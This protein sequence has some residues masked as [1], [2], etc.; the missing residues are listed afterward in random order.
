MRKLIVVATVA[1]AFAIG[2]GVSLAT[3]PDSNGTIHGCYKSQGNS[4]SKLNVID[5]DAGQ[6]CSKGS[7]ELDWSQTGPRG[8]SNAYEAHVD[9]VDFSQNTVILS[10]TVPAGSYV[11]NAKATLTNLNQSSPV[12]VICQLLAP[13]NTFLDESDVDLPTLTTTSGRAAIPL[14]TT[15]SFDTTSTVNFNCVAQGTGGSVAAIFAR[16]NLTQV[17]AIQ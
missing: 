13:S 8:P 10:K 12:H 6:T 17:G 15:V 7:T 2:G 1:G 14:Q 4:M 11:I 9:R 5:T 16:L 3:I